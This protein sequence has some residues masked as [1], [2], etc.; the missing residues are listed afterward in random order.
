MCVPVPG[1]VFSFGRSDIKNL[2]IDTTRSVNQLYWE[3]LGQKTSYFYSPGNRVPTFGTEG[4][5]YPLP[6]PGGGAFDCNEAFYE[7]RGDSLSARA[8]TT[9]DGHKDGAPVIRPY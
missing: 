1:T 3:R 7:H 6:G 2:L 4:C 9:A 8:S 5:R